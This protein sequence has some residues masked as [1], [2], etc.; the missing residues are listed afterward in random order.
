MAPT[1]IA[2][3]F[4]RT[5]LLQGLLLFMICL[6]VFACYEPRDG[7]L[8]IEATNFDAS[9]DKNCC[10]T[11]P[12]LKLTLLPR[13]DT[14]VWKPDTAYEYAPGQWFRLRQAVFYLSD[15]QLLKQGELFA[16]SDTVSLSLYGQAGDTTKQT[17]TNDFEIVRRTVVNYS[18]G[19][20]RT[21]GTF[22]GLQFRIGLPDAAQ[23]VIPTLAPEGHPLRIQTEN[24][25]L[26]Q[27]AG[28][29]ALKLVLTRDT[30]STTAPDTLYFSRPEFNG[31]LLQQTGTFT[32]QSGYD[33]DLKL[34][35]DFREMFR[36]VDL[37]AGDKT[38]WKAQIVA[39]L[40][41]AFRVTL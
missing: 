17:F 19:S 32:H 30:F 4:F 16:V 10:C 1:Q 8:E 7:C 21:S 20:F 40:P 31:L 41:Q 37:S 39:N 12:A 14:L 18:L 5:Y 11:Y 35:A 24:M 34:T 26:G 6:S 25:W 15:F 23:Q 29:A 9:A 13:Y 33:F 36:G 27:G 2:L 28:Y 3:H 22:D 38:A